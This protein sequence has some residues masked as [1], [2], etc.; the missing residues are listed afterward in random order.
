V[1]GSLPFSRSPLAFC[2]HLADVL[3]NRWAKGKTEG[4]DTFTLSL[5]R[6]I[7]QD[8]PHFVAEALKGFQEIEGSLGA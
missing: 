5:W 4:T 3:W 8:A 2:V 7:A 6:E 1:R